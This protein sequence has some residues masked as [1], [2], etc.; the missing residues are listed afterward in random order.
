MEMN[1][2][3]QFLQVIDGIFCPL[4]INKEGIPGGDECASEVCARSRECVVWSVW[5]AHASTWAIV[6]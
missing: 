2:I 5:W 4:G 6:S 3:L 1:S